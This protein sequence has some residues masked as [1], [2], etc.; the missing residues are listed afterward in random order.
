[1][2]TAE[3][4]RGDDTVALANLVAAQQG[5]NGR[6]IRNA[7]SEARVWTPAIVVPDPFS[8]D[9]SKVTLVQRDHPIQAFAPNRANHPFTER[10][11]LRRPRV[12]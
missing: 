1:M 9:S 11:R 7:R 12:T 5:H 3:N 4:R 8:E 6:T 10:V 2:K